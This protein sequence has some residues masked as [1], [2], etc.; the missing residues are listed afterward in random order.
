MKKK[1]IFFLS[2]G[3]NHH[4][5][6]IK[7][8]YK[9]DFIFDQIFFDK[10]IIKPPF[11]TGITDNIK[12]LNYEKNLVKNFK[13]LPKPITIKDFNLK[14]NI[15]LV[16]NLSP[17]LGIVFGTN[18]LS[19]DL[20][21]IFSDGLINIHRGYIQGYRG[22]DSEYWT[23]YHKEY[24]KIGATIHYINNSLDTGKIIDQKFIK[25][26]KKFDL[27]KLRFFTT[28][29]SCELVYKFIRRYLINK[30]IKT[31]KQKKIGKYYSFMPKVIMKQ[32]EKK[33]K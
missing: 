2:K 17:N 30:K 12:Q 14:K 6:L 10:K 33:L 15:N 19:L 25:F 32:I 24:D 31:K 7:Y 16:K 4:K 3:S 18:K 11:A 13:I 26:D 20:I 9:K 27:Y 21:N 29:A 8:L 23:L 28:H 5:Y 22:L 1:K